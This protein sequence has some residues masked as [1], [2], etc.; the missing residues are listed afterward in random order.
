KFEATALQDIIISICGADV[1]GEIDG[2]E[3]ETWRAI[4]IRRGSKIKID[5]LM[6]GLVSYIAIAGGINEPLILGSRS[7]YT[8]AGIGR[9]ITTNT[10]ITTSK[11]RFNEI[12]ETCPSR[13]VNFKRLM[14]NEFRV[15]LGPHLE[16]FTKDMI[17]DF[18]NTRF[19]VT[20]SI[21]RMGYRLEKEAEAKIKGVGRLISCGTIPGAIQIPG[22]GN[23]IVLMAEAQTTGGYAVIGKII[24]TDLNIFSQCEPKTKIKFKESTIDE[25]I[26]SLKESWSKYEEIFREL[27]KKSM[28]FKENYKHMVVKFE[29]RIYDCWIRKS[30]KE[31]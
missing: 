28:E 19:T 30:Y 27:E 21:N 1:K 26:K 5:K 16:Y 10:I 23:P 25:A 4:P 8:T 12:I 3:I 6:N 29:K 22:D 31:E 9:T 2:E 7:H 17:N 13:R 20:S 15:L 18:L 14:K 11:N 24:E